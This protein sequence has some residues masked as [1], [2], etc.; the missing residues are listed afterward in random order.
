MMKRSVSVAVNENVS[1]DLQRIKLGRVEGGWN[2]FG[3]S[4]QCAQEMYGSGTVFLSVC[5]QLGAKS[6]RPG[7]RNSQCE[8]S[9]AVQ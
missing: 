3:N 5:R 6:E 2:F 8:L 1:S 4:G 7:P 9:H